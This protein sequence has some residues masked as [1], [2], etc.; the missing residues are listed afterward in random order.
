MNGSII[1]ECALFFM[2]AIMAQHVTI[3]VVGGS[4]KVLDQVDTVGE[5]VSML[6]D[7]PGEFGAFNIM[8][9]GEAASLSDTLEDYSYISLSEP[10]KG[11]C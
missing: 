5:A 11:G 4:N 3:A 9:N 7:T 2:D 8:I 10:I 1:A 6:E